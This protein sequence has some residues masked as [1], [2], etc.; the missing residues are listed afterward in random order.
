MRA[1]WLLVP[2]AAYAVALGL[3]ALWSSPVD[4]GVDVVNLPPVSWLIRTFGLT[5]EQGYDVTEFAA[6]IALFIPLGVFTMLLV[7][8]WRWW[9]VTL[10]AAALSGTI[11]LLQEVLRPDRFATLSD[12]VAN[13]AG[14]TIGALLC[15]AARSAA[16]FLQNQK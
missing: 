5:V 6:N 2:M 13:T 11:E 3:I 14:G 4:R 9:Q 15:L 7:P 12:V 16:R 8:T 10:L 1:R